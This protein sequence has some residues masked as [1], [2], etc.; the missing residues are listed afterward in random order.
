MP[1]GSALPG[2]I[3]VGGVGGSG[4]RV[5]AQILGEL[6]VYLGADLN[7]PADNLWFTLLFK[8]PA[9]FRR[10]SERNP[11]A[12]LAG[13]DVFE[14]IM[15]GRFVWTPRVVR[16][17]GGAWLDLL[18]GRHAMPQGAQWGMRRIKRMVRGANRVDFGQYRAW[19]W[20]EPNTHL[21]LEYLTQHFPD[22]KYV[23]MIRHGLDM[24]YSSNDQQLRSWG[25]RYG[26][27][28]PEN[29]ADLPRAALDYWIAANQ[30]TV[31]QGKRLLGER[32]MVLSVD[33][34]CKAPQPEIDKLLAFLDVGAVPDE[35][36]T[37]LYAMPRLPESAGRYKDAG[38]HP[39][40]D[41]QIAA[42]RAFGFEVDG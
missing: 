5:V 19:G 36:R 20:K 2:P 37:R 31:E 39:F 38:L 8:R 7:K 32:F 23:H 25:W 28:A 1:T 34:L 15:T 22:L 3:V 40:S 21:Y 33:A 41:E 18:T 4:T 24:A 11:A 12:I 9:W 14:R 13:L 42:V 35:V 10:A 29:S 17:V 6:G 16:L 27:A 26:L 30:T